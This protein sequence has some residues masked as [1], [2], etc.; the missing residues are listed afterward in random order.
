MMGAHQTSVTNLTDLRGAARRAEGPAKVFTQIVDLTD[1]ESVHDMRTPL[2]EAAGD[3]QTPSRTIGLF[4]AKGGVG[5]TTLACNVGGALVRRGLNAAVVDMDLQL[6]AVPV[7]L[8]VVPQRSVAEV[9][10]EV[11]RAG[12]GPV[13]SGLD[14][15]AS[16]LH[17]L[18]QGDRIEEIAQVSSE[19]LPRL[20]D[21]MGRTFQYVVVDGLRDFSDLS[22]ATL[23]LCN[24]IGVVVTQDVPAVRAAQRA[25]VL[26]ERLGYP[27]DRI[28][29]VLNRWQR[30]ARVSI[31]AVQAA[32]GC[33]VDAIVR[34]DFPTVERA[35]D[36]GLLLAEAAP[37]SGLTADLDDLLPHLA[38]LPART[39]QGRFARVFGTRSN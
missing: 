16:G 26:F 4:G 19:R 17:L 7:S 33:P 13:T 23:D 36:H 39:P 1:L 11:V 20:F 9:M 8:N 14:R 2:P 27:A 3:L 38:N 18:A 15:H 30:K 21:A 5:C 10:D 24:V 6:G 29:V 37:K 28:R 31:D 32:L 25:L 34:N 12:S 35:V 22:V